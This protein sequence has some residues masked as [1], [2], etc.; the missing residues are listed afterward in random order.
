MLLSVLNLAVINRTENEY[1]F[2]AARA[3]FAQVHLCCDGQTLFNTDT[4]H[5]AIHNMPF[6]Y[7]LHSDETL[8]STRL[9]QAL[10][11]VAMKHESLHTSLVFNEENNIFIQR[12]I[13]LADNNNNLFEFNESTFETDEQFNN[14]IQ[15]ETENSQYF[16]LSQGLVC[17][18]HIVYYKQIS[19]II[20]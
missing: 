18:C 7:R 11:Q 8:S 16:D 6:L 14:I 9:R 20:F 15:K 13:D 5:V 17:R 1:F 19:S 12:I 2:F 10:Q 3:S 4:Q